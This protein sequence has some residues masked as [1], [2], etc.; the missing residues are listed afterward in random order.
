[1]PVR[2]WLALAALWTLGATWLGLVGTFVYAVVADRDPSENIGWTLL[3]VGTFG[4]VL[5]LGGVTMIRTRGETALA[6]AALVLALALTGFANPF[7]L[8][9]GF[10]G[11]GD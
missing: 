6:I 5:A 4:F 10:G 9:Y 2:N 11:L 3:G 1:M 7:F 8:G